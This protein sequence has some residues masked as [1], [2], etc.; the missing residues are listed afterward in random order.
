MTTQKSNSKALTTTKKKPGKVAIRPVN[1]DTSQYP[2]L[3]ELEKNLIL[4]DYAFSQMEEGVDYGTEEGI[5][6]P[7]LKKP[8]AERLALVFGLQIEFEDID[9]SNPEANF[10][11]HKFVGTAWSYDKN[12]VRI[13]RG[14][15]VGSCS[16]KE[17]KYRYRWLRPYQI[18]TSMKQPFLKTYVNKKKE[19]VEIID[20]QAWIDVNGIGSAKRDNYS[21]KCRF[22]NEDIADLDNTIMKM[23]KKRC[24]SDVVQTVTGADRVFV[25]PEDIEDE[26]KRQK[27]EEAFENEQPP[28][29]DEPPIEAMGDDQAAQPKAQPQPQP[30][31]KE[32]PKKMPWDEFIKELATVCHS[33]GWITTHEGQKI[34]TKDFL[35]WFAKQGFPNCKQIK[36][37]SEFQRPALLHNLYLYRE[38]FKA[39]SQDA[40]KPAQQ[41]MM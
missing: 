3:Q 41:S 15:G 36:D 22:E 13:Y 40:G 20:M 23:A 17:S 32:S 10:Y 37:L 28:E 31:K 21:V 25:R 35:D 19:D 34:F 9:D 2:A 7:F 39:A 29:Q 18:P 14:Q 11:R 33:M 16:S 26:D 5:D 24:M 12:G 1:I 38:E 27:V 6:K 8:G 30:E 4:L